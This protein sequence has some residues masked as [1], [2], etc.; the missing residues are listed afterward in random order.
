MCH[1]FFFYGG[2]CVAASP[3]KTVITN[4]RWGTP[5]NPG[6][7]KSG[8]CLKVFGSNPHE[9]FQDS[10][11]LCLLITIGLC[12]KVGTPIPNPYQ[13]RGFLFGSNSRHV[14]FALKPSESPENRP[15][16][17]RSP[18]GENRAISRKWILYRERIKGLET[19]SHSALPVP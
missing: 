8:C 18:P 3:S 19:E 4:S 13:A 7:I 2:G 16:S 5:S 9:F 6:G 12:F 14:G 15:D 10:I 17:S 11:H 1:Y